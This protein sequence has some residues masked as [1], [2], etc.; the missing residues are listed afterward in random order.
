VGIFITERSIKN[1]NNIVEIH[2]IARD[3]TEKIKLKKELNKSNKM[4]K[5]MCYLIEGDRGGR[6]RAIILKHLAE[7]PHNANQL[8]NI[9]SMDYKTIRHHL[10]VLIKNEIVAKRKS[11]NYIIY[12]LSES[13]EANI[14]D[15]IT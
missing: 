11:E 15:F 2:G 4:R 13:V 8:A 7:K 10:D 14:L 5:L 9:L 1:S 3:I 12:Y 6:T